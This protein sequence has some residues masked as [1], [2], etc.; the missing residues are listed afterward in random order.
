MES[1]WGGTGEGAVGHSP[2]ESPC[3]CGLLG[4]HQLLQRKS[5]FYRNGNLFPPGLNQDKSSLNP[6]KIHLIK[7]PLCVLWS[8]G[9]QI[10]SV[11]C[12]HLLLDPCQFFFSVYIQPRGKFFLKKSGVASFLVILVRRWELELK[13]VKEKILQGLNPVATGGGYESNYTGSCPRNPTGDSCSPVFC[14]FARHS[15]R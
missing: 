5:L 9:R 4:G 11:P 10:I 1:V 12:H 8:R 7:S 13:L 14:F 3:T 2:C 6:I 15:V